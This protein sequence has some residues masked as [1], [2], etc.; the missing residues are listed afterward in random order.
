MI[1]NYQKRKHIHNQLNKNGFTIIEV[2]LVLAIAGLIFLMVFIALPALQRNQRNTQRTND[3]SRF[4]AAIEDYKSKN[5]GQLPF[6]PRSGDTEAI[7]TD[8]YG[9]FVKRYLDS[10]Y[11]WS[12]IPTNDNL[13]SF[14]IAGTNCS[15]EFTDPDGTCYRV[16]YLGQ[17]KN[18]GSLDRSS[19]NVW[20]NTL[21]HSYSTV[22]GSGK[23]LHEFN[24]ILGAACGDNESEVKK[25]S[26]KGVVAVYLLLEGDSIACRDNS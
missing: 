24:V 5:Q 20:S 14:G 10:S 11:Q 19:D 17:V 6:M 7:R 4:L 25:A 18:E 9:N 23:T 15:A 26:G 2:V 12:V 22:T 13:G 8:R 1:V 21:N 16:R 3:L